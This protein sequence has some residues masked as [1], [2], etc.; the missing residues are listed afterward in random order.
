MKAD[1]T[2][3]TFLP[4]SNFSRLLMQQG[5]V[6]L[7]ADWNEQA[8]IE[9]ERLRQLGA[10]L[11]GSH[12]GP[13]LSGY[14][15]TPI[16]A[17]VAPAG[18]APDFALSVGRYYVDGI[19]CSN[20]TSPSIVTGYPASAAA[21]SISVF[22]WTT[23]GVS[24]AVGQYIWLWCANLATGLTPI[25]LRITGISQATQ[26]LTV[27]SDTNPPA[28]TSKLSDF[29]ANATNGPPQFHFVR[30][31]PT[32]LSQPD[33]PGAA[34][35]LAQGNHYQIF[36]DVWERAITY[37][38][39]DRI[40]EVAL[41]GID[42]AARGKIVAQ[43]KA[44]P[45]PAVG[46]CPTSWEIA[47]IFQPANRGCLAAR[48]RPGTASSDPCTVS[49][50]SRYRGPENQLYRVEVHRP[51]LDAA[52]KP[53]IPSFKFSREN[54]SVVFAIAGGGDT[55]VVT[56]DSLGRDD[57]YTLA[58]GDWVEVI[59][60]DYELQNR[61]SP[62]RQVQSIDRAR[63]IVTLNGQPDST[64]GGNPAKH[65]LLRR[66]DQKQ[67]DPAQGGLKL[68]PDGS[69]PINLA[70]LQVN[71]SLNANRAYIAADYAGTPVQ[72][73]TPAAQLQATDWLELEDGVQVQFTAPPTFS[74]P[75]TTQP[76]LQFR[77]GDYWLIPARVA[78]GDVEWPTEL[79]T[80]A[81]G[82]TTKSA[83][84]M[85]PDGVTHH[86]APLAQ[87]SVDSGH[88][89]VDHSCAVQFTIF[90]GTLLF[91][92]DGKNYSANWPEATVVQPIQ[93]T[94]VENLVRPAKAAKETK[95]TAGSKTPKS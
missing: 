72:A 54:G 61:A 10:D 52:G 7:D 4:T 78:T 91:Q 94:H 37:V 64:V 85:Q 12:G 41:N 9:F 51:G 43:V 88:L 58:E 81:T 74:F 59:D 56:L 44:A 53:Q 29:V 18:S 63:M 24:Y 19:P 60:D 40:R 68:D 45:I 92:Q 49:P 77:T 13:M 90:N 89:M 3:K 31:A 66:W 39:D 95:A 76:L 33:F 73:A 93:P 67:G 16:S 65:P 82:K 50:D 14:L 35:G 62:L 83:V 79:S 1:F 20:E 84:P 8:A 2:R 42:T 32:Y 69:V 17:A 75:G 26:T 34:P 38:Q 57:R 11:M 47:S 27:V 5:R 25:L 28:G 87:I 30:R 86:Y 70:A 22:P 21:T 6:Q 36:L 46:A 71:V 80:D 15:V 23:D 48:A 55:N